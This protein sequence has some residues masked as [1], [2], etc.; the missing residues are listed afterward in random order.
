MKISECKL[1]D[2]DQEELVRDL[3]DDPRVVEIGIVSTEPYFILKIIIKEM[4]VS[5]YDVVSNLTLDYEALT[6]IYCEYTLLT[7]SEFKGREDEVIC[8]VSR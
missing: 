1:L 5:L 6:R 2:Y 7:V 8:V 3:L 4:D